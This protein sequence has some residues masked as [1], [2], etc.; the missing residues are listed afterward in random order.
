MIPVFN[1]IAEDI[2]D[3][4]RTAD[5]QGRRLKYLVLTEKEWDE[6]AHVM[7]SSKEYIPNGIIGTFCGLEIVGI[8][9]HSARL[10]QIAK[11]KGGMG[12]T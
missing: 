10:H 3:L 11:Q 9:C 8:E 1:N 6:L 5:L 12:W 7:D 2:E 4:I